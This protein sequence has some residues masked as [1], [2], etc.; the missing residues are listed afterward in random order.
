MPP[1]LAYYDSCSICN[2][3]CINSNR[4]KWSKDLGSLNK[5][6]SV[7][8]PDKSVKENDISHGTAL[9]LFAK[10]LFIIGQ[11]LIKKYVLI[12]LFLLSK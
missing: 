2:V 4:L 8:L 5:G 12:T 6:L 11:E 9:E 7:K 10:R 1:L 3:Y